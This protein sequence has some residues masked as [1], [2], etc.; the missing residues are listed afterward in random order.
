M[1][2]DWQ[3]MR[4]RARINYTGED[5]PEKAPCPSLHFRPPDRRDQWG[6]NRAVAHGEQPPPMWAWTPGPT[7]A[8]VYPPGPPWFDR[9]L[10]RVYNLI[11]RPRG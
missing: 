7:P 5:D 2:P 6:G 11:W 9:V 3:G 8:P 4:E 10:E 1:Y